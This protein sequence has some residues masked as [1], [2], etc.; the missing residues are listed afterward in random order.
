M[1]EYLNALDASLKRMHPEEKQEILDDYREHFAIG[2]EAG[3]SAETIAA[4]LGDPRQIAKMY[5]ARTAANRAHQSRRFGDTMRMLGAA[6]SYKVGGGIA[7]GIL[8]IVAACVLISLLAVALGAV[9]GR[10]GRAGFGGGQLHK[11][12]RTG[13]PVSCSL[14]R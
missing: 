7:I 9:G 14:R 6:L 12:R 2:L 3:K 10:R 1:D 4:E 8:Y 5:T 11:E 13:R